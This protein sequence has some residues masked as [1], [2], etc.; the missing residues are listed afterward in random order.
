MRKKRAFWSVLAVS[1]A[2]PNIVAALTE[3]TTILAFDVPVAPFA[4][5]T[6]S[7]DCISE[8]TV[9]VVSNPASPTVKVV[10]ARDPMRSPCGGALGSKR[11]HW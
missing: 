6:T 3:G 4:Y 8:K 10:D 1:V 9:S 5:T 2:A 11:V 7:F